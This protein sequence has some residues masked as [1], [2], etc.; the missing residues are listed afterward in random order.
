MILTAWRSRNKKG[1]SCC[2]LSRKKIHT[3][4]GGY[5]LLRIA[6]V[7]SPSRPWNCSKKSEILALMVSCFFV[8]LQHTHTHT[9]KWLCYITCTLKK[10]KVWVKSHSL[11][12]VCTCSTTVVGRIHI[13]LCIWYTYSTTVVIFFQSLLQEVFPPSFFFFLFYSFILLL[14]ILICVFSCFFFFFCSIPLLVIVF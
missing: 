1:Q 14:L 12:L 8:H 7:V 2:H 5:R 6:V 3:K 11:L 4:N 9:I 10:G 13:L